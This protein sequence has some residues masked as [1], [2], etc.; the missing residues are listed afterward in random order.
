MR[1][2]LSPSNQPSNVY[3]VGNT[4]EKAQMEALAT[5]VQTKLTAYD[6]ETIMASF[7]LYIYKAERP[8]EALKADADIYL[9]LHTNAGGGGLGRGP[10]AFYHPLEAVSRQLA[11]N[12]VE[13]LNAITPHGENRANQIVNGLTA[14][15]GKPMGEIKS[16]YDLGIPSTL[17]EVDFHDNPLTA[18]YII[19]N[20]NSIADA[21]V[22]ALVKTFNLKLKAAPAPSPTPIEG[23]TERHGKVR[24]LYEGDDGLNVRTSPDFD[25]NI[26]GVVRKGEVFTVVGEKDKF[27]KLL[28]GLYI[29]ASP[30]YVDFVEF[31]PFLVSVTTDVLN[32][33]DGAG[34]QF[35]DVGNVRRGEVYTIVEERNGW[36]RLKSGA[37][38]ISLQYVR[39]V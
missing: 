19:D 29:T 2:Y 5:L 7:D 37:G 34:A 22:M 32:I 1:I 3:A 16:P 17:L 27:Y 9:A 30:K 31:K 4:N 25:N 14:I 11:E 38:W 35:R 26:A 21:I 15:Q 24:V 39:L 23:I 10:V 20:K 36:G 8:T 13:E 28:S 33:R 6:V 18:R 12:L